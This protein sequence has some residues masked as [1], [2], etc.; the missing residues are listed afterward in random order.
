M[1]AMSKMKGPILGGAA[2][3]A[4]VMLMA[5]STSSQARPIEGVSGGR[6]MSYEDMGPP[7]GSSMKPPP[8]GAN[9]SPKVYDMGGG[10]QTTRANIRMRV[11]DLNPSSRNFMRS[12]RE[13]SAGGN[14]NIRTRDDRSILDAHS[15]A[16]KIHERL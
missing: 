7:S 9:I 2:I 11:N 3:A 1:G 6:N 10:G 12:A 15:L 4:G 8:P 5:P 14:V 13:L 16:N